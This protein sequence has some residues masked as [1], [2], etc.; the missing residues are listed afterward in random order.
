MIEVLEVP[1]EILIPQD[2]V[3]LVAMQPFIQLDASR[4]PFQWLDSAKENQVQAIFKT[5]DVAS[6]QSLGQPAKFTIFPEYSI[7]GEEV[8]H[9]IDERLSSVDWPNDTII[10]AG[11]HG[12]SKNEYT[13]L[14]QNLTVNLADSNSPDSVNENSWVNCC[15]VWVKNRN[16]SM[17]RWIQP[18]IRPAWP[19]MSVR[20]RDMF[21]GS[22]IYVFNCKY[23]PSG[24]PCRF[25]V[26]ICFDWVGRVSDK[27]VCDE[28]LSQLNEKWDPNPSPLHWAFVIGCSFSHLPLCLT[29]I[30][31]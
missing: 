22:A 4:E 18:K 30:I 8:V 26:L 1:L 7:P 2:S 10:I 28:I 5:L 20:H 24:Y 27:T 13:S 15:I 19:E 6:D 12:L 31:N 11:L 25:M 16:G 14:C 9:A 21:C 29:G 3:R 17:D 23:E